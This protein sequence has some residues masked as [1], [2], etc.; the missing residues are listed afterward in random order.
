MDFHILARALCSRSN[1]GVFLVRSRNT[2]CDA[3]P[4]N[5]FSLF[6]DLSEYGRIIRWEQQKVF[7]L[8]RIFFSNRADVVRQVAISLQ[9]LRKHWLHM[10]ILNWIIIVNCR[11]ANVIRALGSLHAV[12]EC[13]NTW[14]RVV[15]AFSGAAC[16]SQLL[17]STLRTT[18]SFLLPKL[19]R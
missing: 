4:V 16:I 5:F 8:S 9:T 18:S 14:R 6:S 11:Y 1:F 15:T 17:W 2:Q 19:M 13:G 12:I 10:T 3:A 7:I